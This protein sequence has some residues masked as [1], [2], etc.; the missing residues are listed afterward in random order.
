MPPQCAL[1]GNKSQDLQPFIAYL[2]ERIAETTLS[3]FVSGIILSQ[4]ECNSKLRKK[5]IRQWCLEQTRG[6][7]F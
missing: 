6:F 1:V 2:K 7:D 4:T 5:L 3:L